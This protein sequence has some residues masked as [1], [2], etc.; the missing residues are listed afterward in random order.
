MAI[1]RRKFT[2]K[3]YVKTRNRKIFANYNGVLE[4]MGQKRL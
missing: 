4:K 1:L 2:Q 3:F